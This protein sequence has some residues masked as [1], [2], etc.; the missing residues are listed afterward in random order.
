MERIQKAAGA[1]KKA[2]GLN[3]SR[4][5]DAG[6]VVPFGVGAVGENERSLH[7]VHEKDMAVVDRVQWNH[8]RWPLATVRTTVELVG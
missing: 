5:M 6:C 4:W 8:R 1:T 7:V 3:V 2:H